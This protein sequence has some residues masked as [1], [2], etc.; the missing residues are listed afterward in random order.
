M[1]RRLQSCW[2]HSAGAAA[3]GIAVLCLAA[4]VELTYPWPIKALVDYVFADGP[5]PA[6]LQALWPAFGSRD[7]SGMVVGICLAIALLAAMHQALLL[8]SRY[9]VVGAGN[10]TVRELR[11]RACEHVYRLELAFHQRT[12][13]GDS[14]HR[15]AWDTQGAMTLIAQGIA[16]AAAAVVL[17]SGALLVL[18]G[19]DWLLALCV[20]AVAPAFW[21][22]IRAFG[23]RIERRA[24]SYH[25]NESLLVSNLQESLSA[26]AAVQAFG[27]EPEAVQRLSARADESVRANQRLVWTQLWFGAAIGVAM[28]AGTAAV[29]GVGAHRVL[30]GHLTVGDVLVFLGYLALLYQPV[31]ALS[32]SAAA[33]AASRMQLGR[34]FEVLDR[35]P[36]VRDRP[37]ALPPASVRGAVALRGVNFDYEPGRGALHD[38]DLELEPGSVVALVGST[39]AGKSTL[40]SLLLRFHDPTAGSVQLDGRDLRDLPLAW[41]RS[42]VS[43]VLQ[44]TVLFSA[45]VAENIRYACPGAS[46]A[47]TEEAARL[48]QADAFIRELPEGYDTML[49]ERGANLS[50]GQRQRL[51]IARAFLKDAPLLVLDEPTSALDATTEAALLDALERLVRGRTTLLI[52]HR[53]ATLRLADEIVVLDRGRIVERGSHDTLLRDGRAYRRLWQAQTGRNVLGAELPAEP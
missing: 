44:D 9:L 24:K 53:L 25:E 26:I 27:R 6:L 46:R 29:V 35:V 38:V 5:A 48:A 33:I 19:L 37:G 16:P 7:D 12:R 4:L 52:A 15:I 39:G 34:V 22:L 51:A 11:A 49:G 2:R 31:S 13:V 30:A 36:E 17:L 21:L 1:L 50:A 43:V 8:T 10:R 14:I 47:A 28:A 18:I 23:R 41:L 3:A 42:Q 32:Q 40:A 45:T 20:V